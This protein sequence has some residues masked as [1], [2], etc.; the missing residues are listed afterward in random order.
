MHVNRKGEK[1]N[2]E[3]NTKITEL[4]ERES[5][6]ISQRKS[7]GYFHNIWERIPSQETNPAH[8]KN[9]SLSFNSG[10]GCHWKPTILV[11]MIRFIHV[12]IHPV[13]L[14]PCSKYFKCELYPLPCKLFRN[15][16]LN[17]SIMFS[18]S[19][20]VPLIF[21]LIPVLAVNTGNSS[22]F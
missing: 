9:L 1:T 5:T 6:W 8:T 18:F 15:V 19:R 17:L 22:V 2:L 14:S 21:F 12:N 10:R 16:S 4:K 7:R 20:L 3:N 11:F 13:L